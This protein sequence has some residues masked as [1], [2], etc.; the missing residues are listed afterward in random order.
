MTMT[1]TL[2]TGKDKQQ[3]AGGPT[4]SKQ[5]LNDLQSAADD[6]SEQG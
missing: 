2:A 3:S 5:Q 6:Q 4:C 1:P